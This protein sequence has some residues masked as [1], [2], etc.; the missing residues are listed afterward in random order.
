MLL[1]FL[2]HP[3]AAYTTGRDESFRAGAA[4]GYVLQ[5]VM[6]GAAVGALAGA[7]YTRKVRP[8]RRA[9]MGVG[10]V[11]C[12]GLWIGLPLVAEE[13]PSERLREARSIDDPAARDAA[14]FRAG[15]LD[16]CA[17]DMKEEA[18][19]AGIELDAD[20]YCECL[21]DGLTAGPQDDMEQLEALK[22]QVK[23]GRTTASSPRIK[24]IQNRCARRAAS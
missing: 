6:L 24:R 5:D 1:L 23:A 13:R 14:E 22:R 20:L 4:F 7:L 15:I 8:M 17:E 9:L 16:A 11:V 21:L 19:R 10:L 18:A 2:T 3:T 12:L